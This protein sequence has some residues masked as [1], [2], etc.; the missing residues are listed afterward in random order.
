M[1]R[2]EK[3]LRERIG[4]DP[5][6]V[7]SSAINRT[8]RLRMKALGVAVFEEYVKLAEKS[9]AEWTEL[10]EAIVVT[11]TWFF[12]DRDPFNAFVQLVKEHGPTAHGGRLRVLSVPCSS[13]E[14]PYSLVMALLDAGLSP[15]KF[16][17]DA[18]DISGRALNRA[19]RAIYGRNSF[20]GKELGFRD[21]YFTH[22]KEGYLLSPAV[23][24]AVRFFEGNILSTN[25]L[26][27][28]ATYDF[29]FCRNLLIYFDGETQA[30]ALNTVGRLLAPSGVLM[31]GP[32]EQPLALENGFVSAN[33]PM[34]FAC[35]K[36]PPGARP[37]IM[38]PRPVKLLHSPM[39]PAM[40]APLPTRL[41]QTGLST[42]QKV[43]PMV[44]GAVTKGPGPYA[45]M[46]P[47]VRGGK[48][49]ALEPP[50]DLALARRLA[51]QGKLKEAAILCQAHLRMEPAS[52]Q[53]WYLLGLVSDARG[54][55]E[56]SECYR[57][58][59]Y[60]NPSHY[61]TLLQLALLS[62]KSGDAARARTFRQ[63]AARIRPTAA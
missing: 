39:M 41:P 18:A 31:V 27:P 7:G 37:P 22:T 1:T 60:L 50:S 46:L 61:E 43:L 30:R 47:P 28:R 11:E 9:R 38:R 49:L 33:I 53:A 40:P 21:R 8:A 34:S 48:E 13:G 5:A 44:T 26:P 24:S 62:E 63:R 54:K 29:V 3:L 51:D 32:A 36:G 55:P 14:E 25:F 35:R 10:V 12:R 4:L 2:I 6:S 57:K 17:I 19:R 15:E 52:A 42:T 59:L 56:A 58:A 20:R 23:R 45:G 16:R